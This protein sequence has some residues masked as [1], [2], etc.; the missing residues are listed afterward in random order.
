MSRCSDYPLRTFTIEHIP[1]EI[2]EEAVLLGLRLQSKIFDKQKIGGDSTSSA[3]EYVLP[4]TFEQAMQ[5]DNR[6]IGA[7]SPQ[8]LHAGSIDLCT[9]HSSD[10][11]P[12]L[13]EQ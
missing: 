12:T 2:S 7:D 4:L 5:T 6:D 1:G 11:Q 3:D 13:I 9:F 8:S 10:H